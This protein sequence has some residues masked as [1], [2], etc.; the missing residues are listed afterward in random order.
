MHS[1]EEAE[2]MQ[3]FVVKPVGFVVKQEEETW[4][5]ISPSFR[6]ALLYLD[7]F[8][9]A[10]V[11]W[12]IHERDTP[13]GR[14]MLIAR[15]PFEKAPPSGIFASRSPNRPNP[16][17]LTIVRILNVDR[18]E[19]KV[20]VDRIDAF[21]GSPI[22]DIKGYFPSSDRVEDAKIPE[23]FEGLPKWRPE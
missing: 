12:W 16:I 7:Q 3:S 19:G 13:E 2:D 18:E 23:W 9:H 21:D 22:I 1:A 4:L 5:Q 15:P 20:L 6:E 11:L 8:S 14:S 10:V 17:G